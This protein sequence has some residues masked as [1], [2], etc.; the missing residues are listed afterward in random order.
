MGQERDGMRAILESYDSELVASEYSPQLSLRVKEAED[1]LQKVQA[2]NAEMEVRAN[3][4][5]MHLG[6]LPNEN[7]FLILYL[8]YANRFVH[9][10]MNSSPK[11]L[12]FIYLDCSK[13]V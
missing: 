4:P 5:I 12:L 3:F 2:H 6:I 10:K 8:Y 13:S 7:G 1:M 11:K 9:K